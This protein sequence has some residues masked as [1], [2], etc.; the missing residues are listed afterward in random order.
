M[1]ELVLGGEGLIGSELVDALSRRGDH[2]VSL[3]LKSGCDLRD[4]NDPAFEACDR[5]WFLAWDTGGAKYIGAPDKQHQ[6]Y[7]H[8]CELSARVFDAL[9]RTKKPFMFVTSQLA[10]Q[11]N[12][13][14]LTKLMAERWAEQLGGKVARLWNTYGFERPDVR[15]HVI[16][17]F[18]LSGLVDGR[19]K[20]MTNGGERRRFIYKSECVAA[21]IELFEGPQ[22]TADIA[23]SEWLTIRQVALEVG[24]LLNVEVELG[25]ADG[26]ELIVDPEN[27]LPDWRPILSLNQGISRVISDARLFL[28]RELVAAGMIDEARSSS[29]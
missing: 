22:R 16:T 19:I 14:G 1:R 20:C 25:A 3:D 17:D 4:I 6:M 12:A 29:K 10:G 8:N 13:Y 15:S 27:F 5:V 2:V 26:E 9:S 18:V 23:G 28:A 11:P 7:K 24:D 21:L